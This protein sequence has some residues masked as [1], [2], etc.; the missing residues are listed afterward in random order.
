MEDVTDR[1]A[2]YIF[3]GQNSLKN[4]AV[5]LLKGHAILNSEKHCLTTGNSINLLHFPEIKTKLMAHILT[6]RIFMKKTLEG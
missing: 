5:A 3:T 2:V 4:S 1:Q 6:D